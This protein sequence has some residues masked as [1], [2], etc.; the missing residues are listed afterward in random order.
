MPSLIE[1]HSPMGVTPRRGYH[2]ASSDPDFNVDMSQDR[3]S[4]EQVGK[5]IEVLY[6]AADKGD[7]K[8]ANAR[9]QKLAKEKSKKSSQSKSAQQPQA[10]HSNA[11]TTDDD[12]WSVVSS[13]KRGN[14]QTQC[15]I[16]F[17]AR[18]EQCDTCG[19]HGITN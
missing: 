6:K 10:S 1:P 3:R 14:K 11:K 18:H 8:E 12:G 9:I 5:I 19:N 7:F 17:Q 4:V 15:I 16:D 2:W 13:K